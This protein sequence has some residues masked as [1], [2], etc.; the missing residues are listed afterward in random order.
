MT[1][2]YIA[3]LG[4]YRLL[5]LINWIVRALTEEEYWQILVW[6]AGL[7]QNGLYVDFFYHYLQSMWY[8]QKMTLPTSS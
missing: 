7:V 4:G 2:H 5:Y 6:G 8:K 3:S 1:A